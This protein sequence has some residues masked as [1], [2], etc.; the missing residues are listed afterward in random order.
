MCDLTVFHAVPD[1]PKKPTVVK[2]D[3]FAIT[4]DWEEPLANGSPLT[5]YMVA[6]YR[7][8][9]MALDKTLRVPPRYNVKTVDQLDPGVEYTIQVAAVNAVRHVAHSLVVGA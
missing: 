6:V 4:I 3:R 5:E 8:L 2:V 9:G 1:T 7:T